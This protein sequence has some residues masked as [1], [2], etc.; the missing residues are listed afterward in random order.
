MEGVKIFVNEI[1]IYFKRFSSFFLFYEYT[2]SINE[3]K[4]IV[5]DE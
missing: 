1:R 4:L 5:F 3:E 2:S